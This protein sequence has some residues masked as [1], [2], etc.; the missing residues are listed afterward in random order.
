MSR[1]ARKKDV[2]HR[3]VVATLEAHGCTVEAIES[4]KAG[5]PDLLVGGWCVTEL[6]EVKP[7]STVKAVRELRA[8]QVE[9]HRTWRGRPVVV[10][11][12]VADCLDLVAR[13]RAASSGAEVAS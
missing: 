2:N 4:G 8:S 12:T 13:M 10:V 5:V 9:W 1:F 11:R 6:V 3:E 7:N